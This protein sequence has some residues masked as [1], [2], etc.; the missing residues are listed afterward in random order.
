V[1]EGSSSG[2]G[3]IC[4]FVAVE[5]SRLMGASYGHDERTAG[6]VEGSL[7]GSCSLRR[8]GDDVENVAAE[9]YVGRFGGRVGPV[10]GVPAAGVEAGGLKSADVAASAAAVVEDAVAGEEAVG[11][12][13]AC[14]Q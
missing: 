6:E 3:A 4:V 14:W 9:D 8:I 2:E 12:G 11:D 10:V 7:Q 1:V 13:E 5:V